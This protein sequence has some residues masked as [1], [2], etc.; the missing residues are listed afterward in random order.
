MLVVAVRVDDGGSGVFRE[1]YTALLDGA[2]WHA[3]DHYY[4]LGDFAAC[5]EAKK[6][7]AADWRDNR[8]AFTAKQWRNVCGAGMFSADRAVKEYAKE[9]WGVK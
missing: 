5:L 2:A 3:P 9:I 8:D 7:V 6:Q 1:L 4:V